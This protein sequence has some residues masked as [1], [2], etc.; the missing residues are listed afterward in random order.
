MTIDQNILTGQTL[1]ATGGRFNSRIVDCKILDVQKNRYYVS[2]RYEETS[3]CCYI[4]KSASGNG[5][6]FVA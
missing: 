3:G 1:T 4:K 2:Y 6:K 5:I